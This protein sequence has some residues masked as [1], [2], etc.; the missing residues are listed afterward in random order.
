MSGAA[1]AIRNS[2]ASIL[3]FPE[4]GRTHGEMKPF[5]DGAAYIAIKAGVPL[6][7][8]AMIG[9]RDVLPLGSGFVVGGPVK[10][11]IGDPIPAGGL[12]L[13]DR[14]ALTQQ[15]RDAV[16]ELCGEPAHVL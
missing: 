8:V 11:K 1:R 9:V 12:T 7:P 5:R 2:G 10:V 3:L 15:L 6:V 16:M 13:H 14:A 4:G